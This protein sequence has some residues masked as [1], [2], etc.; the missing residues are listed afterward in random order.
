M[1]V[2]EIDLG[3]DEDSKRKA[4]IENFGL[5][6][7]VDDEHRGWKH[8]TLLEEG[9]NNYE[10]YKIEFFDRGEQS[11]LHYHDL[12]QLLMIDGNQCASVIQ[13]KRY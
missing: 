2:K 6:A 1:I 7:L 9:E 13:K 3:L 5:Q 4:I 12:R 10:V 8:V 11:Q